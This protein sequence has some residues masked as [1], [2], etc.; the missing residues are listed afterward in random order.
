[1]P[2]LG[3]RFALAVAH[4]LGRIQRFPAAAHVRAHGARR[5][6]VAGFPY[7]IW[8]VVEG[9]AIQV[10]AISHTHRLPGYWQDRL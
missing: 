7:G 1:M 3:K 10:Y 5:A 6:L 8:Y 9:E 2:G 4:T